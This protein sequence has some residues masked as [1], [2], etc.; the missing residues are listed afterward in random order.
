MTAVI[1]PTAGTGSR[2]EEHTKNINKSLLPYKNKPILGHIIDNFPKETKFFIPVGNLAQQVKDFCNICYKDRDIEFIDIDDWTSPNSGT[3][4]TLKQ[5]KK[6][7]NGPFWFVSCDTY[8]NEPVLSNTLDKNCYFVKETSKEDSALYTMFK[9]KDSSID[10]ISFKQEQD[11]DWMAFTGLMYIHDWYDFFKDLENHKGVE[12]IPIIKKGNAVAKLNTWMDFG[13]KK[14]YETEL[15][16]SQKFDFSKNDEITYICNNRVVKWWLDPN[17]AKKKYAKTLFNNDVFPSNCEYLG[18]YIAYDFYPGKTLYDHNDSNIIDDYLL[19]LKNDVWKLS[20]VDLNVQCLNFYKKK[21]LDRIN[22]FLKKYPNLKD[23]R[24]VDNLQV[25]NYKYYLDKIDWDYLCKTYVSGFIHGDLHF[26]NTVIGN[27]KFKIIDWRH[28]FSDSIEVGDVYYD[29]AKLLGGFIINYSSIK[30]NKFNITIDENK[31]FL[32]IPHIKNIDVYISK[33]KDFILREG[34][35]Y[36]KVKTIVPI[37]YWN[38]SP[39]HTKPFDL[40]LWYL[41]IKLFEE[42]DREYN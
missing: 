2:M 24:Y 32:D 27:N 5:C 29:L 23:I 42:L 6:Y 9:I 13:S 3:G 16:K 1:I 31:V 28:E 21:T 22:D 17:I 4:Y 20:S 33:L 10:D 14:I 40:F 26:D 35:D 8:F 41:G 37:I 11:E 34:Y 36:K 39:L 7:I 25:K 18:N 15:A 19:W 30:E 12:Y 38:M